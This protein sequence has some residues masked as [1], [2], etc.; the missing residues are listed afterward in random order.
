MT[1]RRRRNGGVAAS[2]NA[3]VAPVMM[4][5]R[6]NIAPPS[7]GAVEVGSFRNGDAVEVQEDSE[8]DDE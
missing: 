4:R 2:A 3:D 7:V 6:C 8:N 5:Q 1:T